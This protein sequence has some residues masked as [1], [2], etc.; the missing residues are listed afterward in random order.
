LKPI[1][2]HGLQIYLPASKKL[3]LYNEI[4]SVSGGRMSLQHQF[5]QIDCNWVDLGEF[6]IEEFPLRVGFHFVVVFGRVGQ[7]IQE[8]QVENHSQRVNVH[9]WGGNLLA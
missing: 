2:G 1:A 3:M 7:R 5:Q 8:Q 6:E 4:G 9:F